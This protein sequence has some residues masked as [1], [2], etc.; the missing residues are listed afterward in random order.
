MKKY[1]KNLTLNKKLALTA[2]ALGF[3]AIFAGN[4]NDNFER[5][6]NTKEL[7]LVSGRNADKI[8]VYQLSDKLVK[9]DADFRLIDLRSEA[10]FNEYHI[11][12]AENIPAENLMNSG[13]LRNE[14]IILYSDDELNAAQAW[15]LLR[16][17]E[18]NSS[19]ILSG[20]LKEWNEKILFPA[21]PSDSTAESLAQFE[22]IAGV[23]RFFGG[24]PQSASL[25]GST[26]KAMIQKPKLQMPV[27]KKAAGPVG[28]K[29][30]EGC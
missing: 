24:Q 6:V 27:Q 1:T 20:G 16:A 23:S 12:E 29:K 3:V 25:T 14:K 22:K 15:F 13:L 10:A 21:A 28:K 19:Y 9:G 11:P 26:D 30:K 7:A 2:V 17:N 4:I 18:Y 5:T 8:S